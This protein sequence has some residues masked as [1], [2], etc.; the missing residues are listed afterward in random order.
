M[1]ATVSFPDR[2]Y[3]DGPVVESEQKEEA[4]GLGRP[5]RHT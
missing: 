1:A 5:P 3:D 4:E 2:A